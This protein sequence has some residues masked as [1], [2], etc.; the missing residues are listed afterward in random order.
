MKTLQWHT[1]LFSS[2]DS[3]TLYN[4]LQLRSEVFVVEQNCA[5]QDLDG[6]DHKALHIYATD[7]NNNIAAYARAFKAN[8]YFEV[9]SFGRV[10]VNK[11]FRNKGLG[12]TLV[13]NTI[14]AIQDHYNEQVIKISAQT[15]LIRFY[16]QHG[17]I[18][19][20]EP[21]LEDGIPHISMIKN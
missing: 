5:Y 3:N 13:A 16:N 7:S 8:D 2:I 10:V 12:H 4:I 6:K 18:E 14:K 21:Y 9:A 11:K 15:Y 19:T 1:K 20:G 17:F